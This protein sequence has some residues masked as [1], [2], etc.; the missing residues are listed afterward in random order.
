MSSRSSDYGRAMRLSI[1]LSTGERT[2]LIEA[3]TF[4]PLPGNLATDL[5]AVEPRDF[6]EP[7]SPWNPRIV[8]GLLGSAV[9]VALMWLWGWRR[10]V[11][12]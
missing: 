9:L 12:P 6:A 7:A 8:G 4:Q 1:S 3:G 5:L 11:R 2:E 10:S